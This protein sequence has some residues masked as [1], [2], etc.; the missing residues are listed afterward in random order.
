M[1]TSIPLGPTA[2]FAQQLGLQERGAKALQA[3]FT[4]RASRCNDVGAQ[5]AV[6]K[7]T[8]PPYSHFH[9]CV[10]LDGLRGTGLSYL[11]GEKRIPEL[12]KLGKNLVVLQ[13]TM[14]S[15]SCRV[16]SDCW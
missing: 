14:S 6:A 10:L 13:E 3:C 15:G 16:G 2:G 4:E 5:K 12:N 8:S 1:K 7:R 9:G 11:Q